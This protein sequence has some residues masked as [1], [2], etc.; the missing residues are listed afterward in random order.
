MR[1]IDIISAILLICI[2]I[3]SI[4]FTETAQSSPSGWAKIVSQQE[5]DGLKIKLEN[6]NFRSQIGGNQ[7]NDDKVENIDSAY[8]RT[9]GVRF[10]VIEANISVDKHSEKCCFD[11][12][13]NP[14]GEFFTI[15]G[16]CDY[17]MCAC[18]H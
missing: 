4:V 6:S 13:E 18:F 7:S 14:H 2:L 1:Q 11:A 10:Y 8:E 3:R 17:E 5:L 15:C 9:S 16:Q 12:S